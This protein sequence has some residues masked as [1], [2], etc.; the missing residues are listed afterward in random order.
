M[1]FFWAGNDEWPNDAEAEELGIGVVPDTFGELRIL[2]FPIGGGGA[3]GGGAEGGGFVIVPGATAGD[4][5]VRF[6]GFIPGIFRGGR[7]IESGVVLIESPLEDI[8]EDIVE[9][10]RVGL[11][12]AD[13]LVFEIAIFARPGVVAHGSGVIAPEVGGGGSRASGVFPFGFGGEAIKVAGFGA[14]P[15]AI[16]V[17]GVLGHGDGGVAIFAHAEA[18]FDVGLSGVSEGVGEGVEFG[19]EVMGF[20]VFLF[21]VGVH[22]EFKLGPSDLTFS[23]IEGIDFDCVDG[24][25]VGFVAGLGVWASHGEFPTGDGEHGEADFGAGN[26]FGVRLGFFC[27]RSFFDFGDAGDDLGGEG[28]FVDASGG[29]FAGGQGDPGG[30]FGAFIDPGAE[31]FGFFFGEA[32]ES[33]G[34]FIFGG[35]EFLGVVGEDRG[36]EEF[37]F[38]GLAGDDGVVIG[39]GGG[40]RSEIEFGVPG[41]VVGGFGVMAAD[42][43]EFEDGLDVFDEIDGVDGGESG[44]GE[45]GDEESARWFHGRGIFA[46]EG[47]AVNEER[48]E[49][50][51]GGELE[52]DPGMNRGIEYACERCTACCRWPG[53]VKVGEEE[54]GKL[55]RFL[56]M[57]EGEFLEKYT[58]LRAKRDGLALVDKGLDEMGEVSHECIFLEGRDCVVQEVKPVQCAGFPNTWNF[59][60]WREVC[61]AVPKFVRSGD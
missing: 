42:A 1:H 20:A 22:E 49:I 16:F 27:G 51:I 41:F 3:T 26:G 46:L 33:A 39:G 14:E 21:F 17:G 54:I 48:I 11:F 12:F 61:A 4:M 15:L 43:V 60:G 52:N 29:F 32:F 25:F 36:G 18:H 28:I 7:L 50:S 37:T 45:E 56:G 24:A 6:G 8:A 35:H 2:D 13:L 57:G 10:P 31:D 53:E 34:D 47:E 19:G 5:R 30:P 58:R 40:I 38:L 59:P 55:A 9:A 44:G 23:H